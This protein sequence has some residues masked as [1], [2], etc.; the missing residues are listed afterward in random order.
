[1]ALLDRITAPPT[2]HALD[3]HELP[4]LAE[5]IRDLVIETVSKTGGHLS[6]NLGV[7]ELTVALHYVFDVGRDVI[8]WD[9]GDQAYTH[10]ILTGRKEDFATLRQ[11]GG[12]SGYTRRA[13][14][15]CDRFDTGHASTAVS[16]AT[17]F[18]LSRDRLGDKHS[19]IAVV[20]DGGLTGGMTYEALDHAGGLSTPLLVVFND[21]GMSIGP[22]VGAITRSVVRMVTGE[23][24]SRFQD[25]LENFISGLPR[26]GPDLLRTKRRLESLAKGMVPGGAFFEELGFRYI[27]PLDGHDTDVLVDALGNLKTSMT[28]PTVLHVR[29]TKGRGY[30]PA[31]EHP[32]TFHC[33]GPF[34]LA[35]G[36]KP[37]KPPRPY[38]DRFGEAMVKLARKNP[39]VC[40]VSAAMIEDTGLSPFAEAFP[41]RTFDV[42]IAVEH[43]VTF[44]A[45]LAAS[46]MRPVCAV[47]STFLQRAYDQILH[48]VAR[49]DLP[50]VFAVNM[51]GF[52]VGESDA[53]QGLYDLTYLRTIPGMTVLA[54]A[55]EFELAEMLKWAITQDSPV[56]IRYPDG[57]A[58]GERITDSPVEMG[59]AA[60]LRDGNDVALWAVGCTV[61]RCV[62][63]AKRLSES[64][65]DATVVNARF[66]APLDHALLSDHAERIGRI[67]TVEENVLAGGFGSAVLEAITEM[68]LRAEI[69]CI[70]A[71]N[72]HYDVRSAE[73]ARERCG[74]DVDGIVE[75]MTRFVR[76]ES[77]EI[78]K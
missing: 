69:A 54:P 1:L 74:L 10:K 15:E 78:G 64:G 48:D 35:S 31:E 40:A 58:E 17:G 41:E 53:H 73:T 55:D 8:V 61:S 70:A 6:S 50:V 36:E 20:G 21:N 56:A 11:E 65:V 67:V 51:A 44:A 77:M 30:A 3:R 14:S 57:P 59:K 2:L 76:G 16:A 13:E 5:E 24:Y 60:V 63:V 39:R 68:G 47:G 33:V 23:R 4:V 75:R 26:V 71:P 29:T 12:L 34:D 7:I 45:G 43:A 42:A 32:A 46:G 28:A 62:E 9:V 25:H 18:A 38:L 37:V 52:V 27:G 49:Q 19:V 22:S 72:D 66:V